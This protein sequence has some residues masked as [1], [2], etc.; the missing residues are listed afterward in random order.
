MRKHCRFDG[1]QHH[2]RTPLLVSAIVGAANT[3]GTARSGHCKS[4]HQLFRV[5][6]Q[7]GDVVHTIM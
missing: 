5:D 6:L 1:S 7:P 2:T 3:D 4:Q